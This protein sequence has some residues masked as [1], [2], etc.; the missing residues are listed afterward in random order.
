MSRLGD[1]PVSP[2]S[3]SSPNR[4][5]RGTG[6]P[7]AAGPHLPGGE[8][9]P[10]IDQPDQLLAVTPPGQRQVDGR[11]QLI[12]AL[13]VC[14]PGRFLLRNERVRTR[15]SPEAGADPERL[16]GTREA[17]GRWGGMRRT[18][19][20]EG[21]ARLSRRAHNFHDLTAGGAVNRLV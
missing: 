4:R 21:K 14:R 16:R 15:P 20:V 17:G 13:S 5:G 9:D 12:S 18:F 7:T 10:Q 3:S 19:P 1:S 8:P 6:L 11:D 2:A